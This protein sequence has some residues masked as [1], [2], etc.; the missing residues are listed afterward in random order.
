MTLAGLKNLA[1]RDVCI[2]NYHSILGVDSDPY[3]NKNVYRTESEFEQDVRFIS[4]HFNVISASELVGLLKE[5]KPL[6]KDAMVI[7]FDD[8][9]RINYDYQVPILRKCKVT[10]TFF[11]CSAFMDN[12]ELHYGRKVNLLVQTLRQN[13]DNLRI[14]RVRDYLADNG[15]FSSDVFESLSRISYHNRKHLDQVGKLIDVDF[16]SYLA[17]KKPYLGS[18][19][20]TQMLSD[21]FSI[22]AHSID[23]P[24]FDDL[25]LDEQVEQTVGSLRHIRDRFNLGYGLFAFPYNDNVLSQEYYDMIRPHVDLTFGMAGFVDDPVSFNFQRAEVESTKL[26]IELAMKYRFLLSIVDRVVKR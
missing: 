12:Q 1:K 18:A 19:E 17:D 2:V 26:P 5:G 11:I 8:G 10:A 25:S 20:I 7:T 14:Q 22:G 4:K 16:K 3:I 23:H 24:R 13:H 6:P 21:G 15:L 9:L